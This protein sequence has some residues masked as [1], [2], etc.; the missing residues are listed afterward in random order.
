MKRLTFLFVFIFLFTAHF[1]SQDEARLIINQ[2]K[3]GQFMFI[4]QHQFHILYGLAFPI[5]YQFNFA[6]GETGIVAK[7]KHSYSEPWTVIPEKHQGDIFN[8]EEV[9]R[10]DYNKSCAF[11]SAAFNYRDTLFLEI[12]DNQGN[13][14]N[15]TYAG[16]TKY[17]DNRKAAVTITADDWL[18]DYNSLFPPLLDLFRS[19]GLY[20]TA[21]VVTKASNSSTWNEIQNQVNIGYVEIASHSRTHPST[22][23][24]D[25]LG[26]V[27][28]SFQ[29]IVTNLKLPKYYNV[30]HRQYVFVWIAPSGEYDST[31]DALLG[32]VNCL[33]PRLYE[34]LS[35]DTPRVYINGFS[36][37]SSWKASRNHFEAF[38]PTVE[39][40]APYWGGGDTSL[41]SLNNLFDSVVSKGG[42]YHFMWHPQV[43][44][45]DRNKPYL[46]NHLN[47]V[48]RHPD[49]WYVNLGP[50]Y[51][52]HMLQEVNNSAVTSVQK[53]T[54]K[55]L[56]ESFRLAQNF[57]NPFNPSTTIRFELPENVFVNINV[58]NMLGEKV[59]TLVNKNMEK[60]I[61]EINFDGGKLA[62]STYVYQL[63]AS[64]KVIAQKMML[65]K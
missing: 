41:T 14:I 48:S 28:G 61:H 10:F 15:S 45:D 8:D 59:A 53:Q 21:G 40:G 38:F 34:N 56:P 25:P 5:T 52:Y 44:Y 9:V 22:P 35:T 17:Y 26:E 29:D 31:V 12:C 64:N 49:L 39:I 55:Y 19:Y 30:N 57:P 3:Q 32:T 7:E 11:V 16:I 65:L 2:Q 6:P 47:Y 43:I 20:V 24:S 58:Y 63:T 23:Y 18:D 37:F 4:A 1:Y 62:S 46:L 13:A 54:I 33:A 27:N 50:L 60:G 36:T 51:L 42:I